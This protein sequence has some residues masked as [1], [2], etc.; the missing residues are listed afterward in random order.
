MM[1]RPGSIEWGS[2]RTTLEKFKYAPGDLA[3]CAASENR[4]RPF[5]SEI[6]ARQKQ[7]SSRVAV[8]AN[9]ISLFYA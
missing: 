7:F 5:G 6:A 2:K 1:L 3:L 4:N 9:S 8:I